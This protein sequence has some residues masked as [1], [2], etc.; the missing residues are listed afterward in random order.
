MV[1]HSGE[2]KNS[3]EKGIGLK[4]KVEQN[5]SLKGGKTM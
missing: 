1:F 2:E 5:D 3:K 4:N